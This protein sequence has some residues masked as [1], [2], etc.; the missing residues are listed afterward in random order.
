MAFPI[1]CSTQAGTK[2]DSSPYL[3]LSACAIAQGGLVETYL[4]SAIWVK[5]NEASYMSTVP[6]SGWIRESGLI[7]LSWW[8]AAYVMDSCKLAF[9][10]LVWQPLLWLY[11]VRYPG[12]FMDYV[13]FYVEG[14]TSSDMDRMMHSAEESWLSYFYLNDHSCLPL[15]PL[16]QSQ[17]PWFHTTSMDIA[18]HSC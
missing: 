6:L 8:L 18:F 16:W 12:E 14:R 3:V 17:D 1:K 10:L 9:E 11:H 4:T 2:F 7:C 15:Q 5:W 13:S